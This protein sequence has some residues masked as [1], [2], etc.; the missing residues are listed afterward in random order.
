MIPYTNEEKEY[1]EF[2]VKYLD[3]LK[4]IA[5]DFDKL[6]ESNKTRAMIDFHNI[7]PLAIY[8]FEQELKKRN[9]K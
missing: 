2:K 5:Q 3:K 9:S 6:S 4:D 8:N 7:L 1:I